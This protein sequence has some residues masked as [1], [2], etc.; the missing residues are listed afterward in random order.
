MMVLAFI[1][2]ILS[3]GGFVAALLILYGAYCVDQMDASSI[4][5]NESNTQEAPGR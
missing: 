2:V 4:P 1:I 5:I 3:L